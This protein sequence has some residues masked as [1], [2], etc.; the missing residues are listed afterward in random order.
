[1]R[2]KQRSKRIVGKATLVIPKYNNLKIIIVWEIKLVLVLVNC[3]F[4][5]YNV[6]YT[7]SLIYV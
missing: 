2:R 5:I 3:I 6:H 1:M 4:Y 7:I